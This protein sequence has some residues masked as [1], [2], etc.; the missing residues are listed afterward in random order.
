MTAPS[1]EKT[2]DSAFCPQRPDEDVFAVKL[3]EK[4]DAVGTVP[5]VVSASTEGLSPTKIY[6]ELLEIYFL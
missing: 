4:P 1:P 5:C 2:F 3:A 6:D